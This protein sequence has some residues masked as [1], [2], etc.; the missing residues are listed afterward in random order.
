M[1]CENKDYLTEMLRLMKPTLVVRIKIV[2][3]IKKYIN[4][5]EEIAK[6]KFPF[7]VCFN[8]MIKE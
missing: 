6:E 4:H 8:V 3:P 1:E 5:K 2:I 7:L